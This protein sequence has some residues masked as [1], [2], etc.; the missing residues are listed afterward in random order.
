LRSHDETFRRRE[1]YSLRHTEVFGYVRSFERDG[2]SHPIALQITP[3]YGK[4]KAL[5]QFAHRLELHGASPSLE[6]L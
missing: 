2:L 6:A 5:R 4:G 1:D 3:G